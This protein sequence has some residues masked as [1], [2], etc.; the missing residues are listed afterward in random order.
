MALRIIYRQFTDENLK[1]LVAEVFKLEIAVGPGITK[2]IFEIDHRN[3]NFRHDVL[4]KRHK[5]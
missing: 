4:I 5:V 2:Q 1:L 3:Y